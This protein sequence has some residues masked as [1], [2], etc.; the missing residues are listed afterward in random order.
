MQALGFGRVGN[1]LRHQHARPAT[2]L[3]VERPESCAS[4]ESGPISAVVDYAACEKA[5]NMANTS[6]RAESRTI[7]R[8]ELEAAARAY[9]EK[10]NGCPSWENRLGSS[11][12]ISTD[13]MQAALATLGIEVEQPD[14]LAEVRAAVTEAVGECH[15]DGTHSTRIV[16]RV[17]DALKTHL[18]EKP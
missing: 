15:I 6:V 1:F 11:R 13:A 14:P 4:A 12:K 17:L 2:A 5:L 8:A 7:S 16:D 18:K 3:S 9:W 10:I